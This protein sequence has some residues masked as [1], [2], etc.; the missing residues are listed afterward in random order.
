[1]LLCIWEQKSLLSSPAALESKAVH[2]ALVPD[3]E[4]VTT[5]L[6]GL[7]QVVW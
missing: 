7:V 5:L 2:P 6:L 1:V 3:S 4:A